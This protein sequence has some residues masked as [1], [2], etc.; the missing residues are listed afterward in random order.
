MTPYVQWYQRWA[1]PHLPDHP[2]NGDVHLLLS[3]GQEVF[4]VR[5]GG[6]VAIVNRVELV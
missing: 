6:R 3:A 4:E 1:N 5:M 2:V